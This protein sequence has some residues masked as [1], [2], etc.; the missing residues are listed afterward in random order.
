MYV[1]TLD[2]PS[3]PADAPQITDFEIAACLR[4]SAIHGQPDRGWFDLDVYP[5]LRDMAARLEP[6]PG[7]T[8][9]IAAE[10]LGTHPF[11]SPHFPKPP[12][13]SAT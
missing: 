10:A 2:D 3:V 8:A 12:E 4:W 6:R 11:T 13:G 9:A 7:V 5:V 1:F